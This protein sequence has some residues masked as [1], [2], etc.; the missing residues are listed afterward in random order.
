[1]LGGIA[2]AL[3]RRPP[4]SFYSGP[5][6]P[7]PHTGRRVVVIGGGF[8]GLQAV[9]KLR[10]HDDV[11]VT[12]IDRRNFHLF[13]PLVYQVATGALSPG[14]VATPLRSIF[15]RSAER[16]RAARRGRARSTS[17][18]RVVACSRRCRT[19]RPPRSPYDTL[20][21]AGGLEVLLLRPRR[22]GR[23]TR[24][25]SSRWSARST[26]AGG[27]CAAFEAAELEADPE[28]RAERG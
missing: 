19:C 24:R 8:G 15:K 11:D 1:M 18:R 27:S 2:L 13:Q 20:L 16:A 3:I 21:V 10:K 4:V 28:K 25:S 6:P 23:R 12:L 14:E 17:T 9:N 22:V 5:E 26:C 7:K